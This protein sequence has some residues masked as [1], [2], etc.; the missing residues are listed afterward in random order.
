MKPGIYHVKFSPVAGTVFG[1]GLVIF[2]E[3]TVNGGD[4]GYL[5]QGSYKITGDKLAAKL[6]V[7]RWNPAWASVF[8]NLVEYDLDLT[9]QMPADGSL[10]YAE[11]AVRQ[12][13]Q[14]KLTVNGR[15]LADAA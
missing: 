10:F 11:G 9:G 1:E 6:H 4:P 12:H 5:Y 2:R 14:L 3:G 13:P 7:K 15:R 8:G